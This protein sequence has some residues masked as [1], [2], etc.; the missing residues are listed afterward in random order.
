MEAL[1]A[2]WIFIETNIKLLKSGQ[3]HKMKKTMSAKEAEREERIY[4]VVSNC[5]KGYTDAID[6]LS[7]VA[8]ATKKVDH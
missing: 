5:G 1:K 4:N 8:N 6:Y 7:A 2:E 3:A